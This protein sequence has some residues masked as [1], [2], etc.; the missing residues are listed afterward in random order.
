[1]TPRLYRHS[2]AARILKISFLYPSNKIV[3]YFSG[4]P[5]LLDVK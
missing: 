4:H 2:Q 5:V 3:T 1:M